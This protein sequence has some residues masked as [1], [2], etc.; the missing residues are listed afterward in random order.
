MIVGRGGV[1]RGRSKDEIAAALSE[2]RNDRKIGFP[3][4]T[5]GNDKTYR[6][7]S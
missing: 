3:I 1:L 6:I 5:F 7:R 4:K 2:P